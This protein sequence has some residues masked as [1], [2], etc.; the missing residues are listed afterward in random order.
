MDTS[1]YNRALTALAPAGVLAATLLASTTA[2]NATPTNAAGAADAPAS[3][4]NGAQ[5]V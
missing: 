5:A 3:P 4:M 1:S 2:A